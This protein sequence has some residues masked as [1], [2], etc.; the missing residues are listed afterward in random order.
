MSTD[1]PLVTPR[2]QLA[3]ATWAL[4]VGLAFLLFAAGLFGTLLGVRAER[5]GLPTIVSS[6][7]GAAYFVGFIVGSKVAAATVMTVGHIRVFTAFAAILSAAVLTVGLLDNAPA[8]ILLRLVTGMCLAG[9]YVV[10]ESWLN[11]LA[12]NSNRGRL[13]AVYTVVT[14]ATFAVGQTAIGAFDPTLLTGYAVAGVVTSLAVVPVALSEAAEAPDVEESEHITLRELAKVVP[15]GLGSCLLVG[16]AH[17]A[18]GGMA[19]VYATRAGFPAA[20]IGLF[21]A[22]PSIGGVLLQWPISAASDDLDRRAVGLAAALGAA[23]AAVL[24]V[25]TP[26]AHLAAIALFAVLGGCSYPLYTIAAAYTN[27]WVEPEHVNSAASQVVTIY[28]VGAAVGPF[29]AAGL[30]V[31]LGT[32]GFFWSLVALHVMIAA[33]FLYRMRAWKSPLTKRPW[34]E[35]SLP[36]RAFF[37]P[38]TIVAM[39]RRRRPP[40]ST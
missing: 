11:D 31:V 30:L 3:L 10:A 23:G 27:D 20:Q 7:I 17:G 19:A 9:Q 15:T 38:A 39:G 22:A 6:A 36:A 2:R 4:F 33:F 32:D 16:I 18:I 26:E 12:S 1:A 40:R 37:I 34:S 29:T 13:L 5:A 28:G 21:V 25:L 14:T 8:W 24:L 35:V